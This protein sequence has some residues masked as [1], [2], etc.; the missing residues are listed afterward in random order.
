MFGAKS[1]QSLTL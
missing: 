1:D